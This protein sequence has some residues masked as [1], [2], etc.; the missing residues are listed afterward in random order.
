[1]NTAF[2]VEKDKPNSHMKLW[3]EFTQFLFKEVIGPTGVPVLFLGKEAG[4]FSGLIDKTNPVFLASHP[5][6]ASYSGKNWDTNGVFKKLND[7]IWDSNKETISWL[8]IE[9][10]F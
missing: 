10:P 8:R 4:K 9:S 2:T 3:H 6:S 7:C 5:V 1:M